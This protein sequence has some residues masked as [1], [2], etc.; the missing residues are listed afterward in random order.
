[1][2]IFNDKQQTALE[3]A[4]D[5]HDHPE[6]YPVTAPVIFDGRVMFAHGDRPVEM[7]RQR[8]KEFLHQL[9]NLLNEGI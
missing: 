2:T 1:M 5:M 6:L 4:K 8:A 3:K 7:T 9:A